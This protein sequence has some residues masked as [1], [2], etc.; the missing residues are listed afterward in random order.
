MEQLTERQERVME[1][2][3]ADN[4]ADVIT[5]FDGLSQA[6][7]LESLDHMFTQGGN[8]QLATEIYAELKS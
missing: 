3:G 7:I 2:T 6:E 8:E 4:W 1:A 5:D